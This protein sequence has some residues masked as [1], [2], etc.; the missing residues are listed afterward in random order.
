M[1]TP[2]RNSQRSTSFQVPNGLS[3][4]DGEAEA[5]AFGGDRVD[6]EVLVEDHPFALLAGAAILP[7]QS[8]QYALGRDRKLGHPDAD[9][10]VDRRRDRR[11]LRVVRHL[12]DAFR[13]VR[14]GLGGVLDDDRVDLR[15]SLD[16]GR[17]VRAELAAA[18]LSARVVGVALLEHAQAEA[19]QSAALD[20][21]LDQRRVDRAADVE[22]LPEMLDADLAG[23]VVDLDLGGA[24]GV[25]DGR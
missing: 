16:P 23:L 13:P 25:R 15:Q 24:G 6:G 1:F 21:A 20:L 11:R 10:V 17:E 4:T 14:P 19:H 2:G 7:L 22:A 3:G 5:R 18:V 12:A 8:A 9:G